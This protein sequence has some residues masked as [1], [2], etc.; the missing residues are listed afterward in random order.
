MKT[1]KQINEEIRRLAVDLKEANDTNERRRAS[2]IQ[3]EI[4][5]LRFFRLYLET[6]PKPET[7]EKMR[8]D[9]IRKI[10]I[11]EKRFPTW[12]SGQTAMKE[13]NIMQAKYYALAGIPELKSRL[14]ALSYL[15]E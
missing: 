11:L 13:T 7:V 14:K 2:A 15:C 1:L 4:D 5:Q 3:R 8:A 10:D 12:L 9:V 6:N